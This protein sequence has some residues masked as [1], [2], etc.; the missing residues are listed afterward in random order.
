[1]HIKGLKFAPVG[2]VSEA[3]FYSYY[4]SKVAKAGPGFDDQIEH[5]PVQ[6]DSSSLWLLGSKQ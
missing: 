5:P 6:I 2:R 4:S 1:M 3:K